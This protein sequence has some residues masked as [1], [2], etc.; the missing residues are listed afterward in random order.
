MI[1]GGQT[2]V[3]IAGI[4]AAQALRIDAVA[5]LPKGYLQR[6]EDR[7]DR[8]MTEEAVREQIY[9]GLIRLKL[10]KEN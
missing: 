3:D 9:D 10:N 7:I 2:G 6:F 5:T 1:S 8:N 4:V